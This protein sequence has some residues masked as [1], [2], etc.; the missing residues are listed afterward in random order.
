MAPFI[1]GTVLTAGSF[2][3]IRESHFDAV[4]EETGPVT[5]FFG[6][7]T[8]FRS[9][10]EVLALAS[11]L[12]WAVA[13]ILY[14]VSG[15]NVHP[16]GLNLFKNILALVFIA[17]T[18][19]LLGERVFLSVPLRSVG[20]L[21]LSGFLGIAVSDTFFFYSLNRLGA[22]LV[23]IVDCF[24]SPFVIGLSYIIL[25]ERMAAW[26]LIGVALIISA[27]LAASRSNSN[28]APVARRDLVFGLAYGVLAMFFVA[29][30]IVIIKPVLATE[31]VV[32][33]TLLRIVGGTV[34]LG[35][36]IPLLPGR[37]AILSPLLN[38]ANWRAMIP[39]SF[40]GS[41]LSLILW[42]GGM[43]Y[44]RVSVA[45]ALNQLNTIFIVILAAL[46]LKERLTWWKIAAVVLAFLGAYLAAVP[47]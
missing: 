41:Y 20:L 22:S 13:V 1:R 14:R 46:F 4:Y 12:I 21:L 10:G 32:W 8:G 19:L 34:P 45:A 40:F 35:L 16:L 6:F 17:P 33:A 28:G 38:R 25:G 18:M 39:A 24:Y 3:V 29:I 47:L 30:G 37:R 43:K 9:L 15:R 42:M 36:V 11:G 2:S 23:A 44:A 5:S 26:Q 27:V 7:F 31:P